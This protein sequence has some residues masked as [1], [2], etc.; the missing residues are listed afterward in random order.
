MTANKIEVA[1]R[2]IMKS[3]YLVCLQ[4]H[5]ASTDCGCIGRPKT[6]WMEYYGLE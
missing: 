1:R 5:N 4:G 2:T 3:S 6:A